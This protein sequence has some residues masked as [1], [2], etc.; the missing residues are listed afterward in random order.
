VRL[1]IGKIERCLD[2]TRST[3]RLP[4]HV[5][6]LRGKPLGWQFKSYAPEKVRRLHA[7][8]NRFVARLVVTHAKMKFGSTG[9]EKSSECFRSSSERRS[10]A[11]STSRH[12]SSTDPSPAAR[13]S[14]PV[15]LRA[16]SRS[17][18]DRA[19][20][21]ARSTGGAKR[22]APPFRALRPSLVVR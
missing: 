4:R 2:A 8:Q 9:A 15:G 20:C 21:P 22:N 11:S 1:L 16:S 3:P 19:R 12:S 14:S 10:A 7:F 17:G 5:F 13:A 6:P 18:G